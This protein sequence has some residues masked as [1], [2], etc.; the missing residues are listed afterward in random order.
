MVEDNCTKF[1]RD[2]QNIFPNKALCKSTKLLVTRSSAIAE[3]L[4]DALLVE[5]L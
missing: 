5:S 3:E 4:R 2:I 1:G